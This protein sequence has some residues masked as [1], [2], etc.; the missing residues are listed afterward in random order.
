MSNQSKF[1]FI[2]G[3]PDDEQVEN[4]VE[5]FF[6]NMMNILNTF[7]AKVE[8][9]EVADRISC[10]PF[11][12]LVLEQLEDEGEEVKKIAVAR[13]NELAAMEIEY[14]QHYSKRD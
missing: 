6:Y 1:D 7:F 11:E 12:K 5:E 2:N 10:V 8:L 14:I 9:E 3:Q 4:W 13:I